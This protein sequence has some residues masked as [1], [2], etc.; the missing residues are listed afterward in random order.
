MFDVLKRAQI[1]EFCSKE[2][3]LMTEARQFREVDAAPRVLD[4]RGVASREEITF[5]TSEK[6][7][8]V[9][10]TPGGENDTCV[11]FLKTLVLALVIT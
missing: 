11:C 4:A 1:I 2:I 6:A 7:Y 9:L 5:L 3:A 10:L 8:V